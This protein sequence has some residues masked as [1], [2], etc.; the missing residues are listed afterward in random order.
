MMRAM[1]L[2]PPVMVMP[3]LIQ[4]RP[5]TLHPFTATSSPI[6][7]RSTPVMA[8]P[9]AT[10]TA[11][12]T[13]HPSPLHARHPGP[14]LHGAGTTVSTAE[15]VTAIMAEALSPGEEQIVEQQVQ[16]LMKVLPH[17]LPVQMLAMRQVITDAAYKR[18]WASLHRNGLPGLPPLN[19]R[20]DAARQPHHSH[21]AAYSEHAQQQQ[22]QQQQQV[23]ARQPPPAKPQSLQR[24]QPALPG[25]WPS[26]VSA[27]GGPVPSIV[28][29][30]APSS[31]A[32]ATRP[33]PVAG[34]TLLSE[35]AV[36]DGG[37]GSPVRGEQGMMQLLPSEAEAE[38]QDR[39]AALLSR[40][41]PFFKT[42]LP[43]MQV[44]GGQGGMH[45]AA[46]LPGLHSTCNLHI[47][48]RHIECL[49]LHLQGG[50]EKGAT[51]MVTSPGR[52][53]APTSHDALR[54]TEFLMLR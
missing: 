15:Q 9:S 26:P 25:L 10:A 28:R 54:S 18:L 49:L 47:Y 50:T 14:A 45:V 4:S 27:Q 32:A 22:Q 12:A 24:A 13:A 5:I 2:P 44:R 51:R 23:L 46:L 6:L 40:V 11:P 36:L 39:V 7:I 19:A 29:A 42:Y 43:W 8:L 17:N 31:V 21:L 16:K 53:G 38:L 30:P 3:P 52:V 48:V 33:P 1:P 41:H 20:W 37:A 35:A 34:A